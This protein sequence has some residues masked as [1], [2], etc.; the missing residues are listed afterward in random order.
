MGSFF[1]LGHGDVI[2]ESSFFFG[3]FKN[4]NK[5]GGCFLLWWYYGRRKKN[6][7]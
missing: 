5:F 2:E 4:W 6:N 1:V 7:G 3:A